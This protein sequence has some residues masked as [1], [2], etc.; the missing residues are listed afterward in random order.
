MLIV[1]VLI[2]QLFSGESL[3]KIK[4]SQLPE[5]EPLKISV[6]YFPHCTNNETLANYFRKF[7]DI[8]E[9]FVVFDEH[10]RSKKHGFVTFSDASS[11]ENCLCEQPHFIDGAK[12]KVR[13]AKKQNRTAERK[14]SVTGTELDNEKS[15]NTIDDFESFR[16]KIN[17]I[18]KHYANLQNSHPGR[19]I[20]IEQDKDSYNK[21][22]R[23]LQ[24]DDGNKKHTVTQNNDYKRAMKQSHL[25]VS[26]NDAAPYRKSKDSGKKR[27]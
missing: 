18:R 1:A 23:Q 15:K 2:K 24:Y 14:T 13:R 22:L 12:V 27:P 9:S 11:L 3:G 17:N 16:R 7:G 20:V 19:Q 8:T 4:M 5:H 10:G 25:K 26:R 6:S 21:Y